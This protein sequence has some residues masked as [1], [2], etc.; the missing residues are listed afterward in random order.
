MGLANTPR[1]SLGLRP[2]DKVP[3]TSQGVPAVVRGAQGRTCRRRPGSAGRAAGNPASA[4][5]GG[6]DGVVAAGRPAAAESAR[7]EGEDPE[8][9]AER[10][11]LRPDGELP[12]CRG[13]GGPRR[14]VVRSRGGW[15][16]PSRSSPTFAGL[17]FDRR[18]LQRSDGGT[19]R[20]LIKGLE[21]RRTSGGAP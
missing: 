10:S 21:S 19:R 13:P 8:R 14:R 20:H 15:A 2:P 1:S 6:P 4:R 7:L 3:A 9:S 17:G 12:L 16:W 11:R 5:R 18:R